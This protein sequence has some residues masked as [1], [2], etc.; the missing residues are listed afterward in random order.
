MIIILIAIVLASGVFYGVGL[1]AQ[2][3]CQTVHDDQPFLV[4]FLIGNDLLLILI[5]YLYSI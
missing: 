4:S 2:G 1:L 3:A 5:N